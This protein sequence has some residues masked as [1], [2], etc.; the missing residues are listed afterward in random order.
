MAECDDLD[1]YDSGDIESILRTHGHNMDKA[2]TCAS[3]HNA[4]VKRLRELQ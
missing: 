4:L 1:E 3:R 2:G